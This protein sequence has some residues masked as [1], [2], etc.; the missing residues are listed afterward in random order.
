MMMT[1]G[2]ECIWETVWGVSVEGGRRKERILMGEEDQVVV[3]AML[4][5]S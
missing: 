3:H 1:M 4:P 2:H 5:T